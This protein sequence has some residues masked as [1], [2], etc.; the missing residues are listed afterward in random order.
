MGAGSEYKPFRD[1]RS[2]LKA[3]TQVM[4]LKIL[5]KNPGSAK[6]GWQAGK[7]DENT[8]ENPGNAQQGWQARK[9]VENTKEKS[10]QR[11]S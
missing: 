8:E 7:G 1:L 11:F 10:R 4:E 3:G 5:R 2:V 9:G 6:Q